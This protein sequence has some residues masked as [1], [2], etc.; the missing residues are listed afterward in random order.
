MTLMLAMIFSCVAIGLLR[1]SVDG[2][3]KTAIT[4]MATAMAALYLFFD[5]L[6]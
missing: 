2:R 6:M 4:M 3:S 1:P 5:G